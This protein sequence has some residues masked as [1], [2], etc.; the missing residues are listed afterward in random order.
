MKLKN[1]IELYKTALENKD[2]KKIK[3]L[4]TYLRICHNLKHRSQI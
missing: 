2:L 3:I 4:G 1:Y